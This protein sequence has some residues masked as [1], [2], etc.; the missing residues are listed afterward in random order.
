MTKKLFFLLNIFFIYLFSAGVSSAD[1]QKDLIN[2]LTAIKTL[3]FDFKQ[4]I[5]DKEEIGN[6]F[7]K[8][9]LLMKCN[10]Q[11]LKQK[12]IIS[13]GKTV[14]IIKK[15]YKKIYYYPI[16][17]TPLFFILK[18]EKII[19]LIRKNLPT[20]INA[21]LIEFEFIDQKTNKVKILFDKNSLE[22][23]GWKT[24]DVYSN[25]VSFTINNL[26]INNQIIDDFFK[27][28]KEE[29]L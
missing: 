26:K 8:Y 27:I 20:E 16:K 13:N 19:N 28:P 29:D 15:K 24:K 7:I 21:G 2:K 10:Y 3:S 22:F 18:K 4:K 23:K 5:S 6:C 12:T 17:S 14:A 9:P 11:N 25:N 1:L